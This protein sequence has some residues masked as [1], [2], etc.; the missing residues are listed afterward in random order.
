MIS[1]CS[2]YGPIGANVGPIVSKLVEFCPCQQQPIPEMDFVGVN[3]SPIG[4]QTGLIGVGI[5][6]ILRCFRIGTPTILTPRYANFGELCANSGHFCS[7][8]PEMLKISVLRFILV[9]SVA[10]ARKRSK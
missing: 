10:K 6:R 4:P 8:G 3:M 7:Q 2:Q 9:T 1:K 5:C